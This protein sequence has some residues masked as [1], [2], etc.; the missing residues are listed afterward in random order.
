ML[1]AL[2]RKLVDRYSRANAIK[3]RR[4]ARPRLELLE[5][6]L[7]PGSADPANVTA[8][9]DAT[10]HSL[11][12]S[13]QEAIGSKDTPVYGAAFLDPVTPSANGGLTLSA[14]TSNGSNVLNFPSGTTTLG[15]LAGQTV[16]GS[17]IQS[18]TTI[19]SVDSSTQVTLSTPA[20]ATSLATG[21]SLTF[22]MILTGTLT[23]G[24]S[25]VTGLSST[26]GLFVGQSLL[27]TGIPIPQ[28][29]SNPTQGT[30]EIT[31]R[32]ASIGADGHSL[33]LT[34]NATANGAQSLTFITG[35]ALDGS[36]MQFMSGIIDN[37]TVFTQTYTYS[38]TYQNPFL[39]TTPP[40]VCMTLYHNTGVASGFH[41]VVGDGPGLNT[42]NSLNNNNNSGN[43]QVYSGLIDYS[44]SG[45]A[46]AG[47]STPTAA[48]NGTL[49]N[50]STTVTGLS[51][52]NGMYV[53]EYV[54][55][56]G[57][58]AGAQIASIVNAS[59]ITLTTA[60]T[61]TGGKSLTFDTVTVLGYRIINGALDLNHD[62]AISS[63]DTTSTLAGHPQF[64]GFNVIGG[65]VDLNGNGKI[66]SNDTGDSGIAAICATPTIINARSTATLSGY[67]TDAG[68]GGGIS[69]VTI[70]LTQ[71]DINGNVLAT[72][73]TTTDGGGYY[74]FGSLPAGTYSITEDTT[75]LPPG[76]NALNSFPGTDNGTM[77]GTSLS[78]SSI[79][80]ITLNS[81]DVGTN[82]N[83]TAGPV[84]V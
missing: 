67:V 9:Y 38:S 26:A 54:T 36:G 64:A 12:V 5:A 76:Y 17:G 62:G 77:D 24:S 51:S 80:S 71:Y 83:F 61:V 58:H 13:F 72:F 68:T 79:S 59:T 43:Y 8:I 2:M 18:G 31:T 46:D 47:D 63:A 32:I 78:A 82:F 19:A 34:A 21:T 1:S 53:G 29:P 4:R 41:S 56:S 81:G 39:L 66:D 22:T 10:A 55:G 70:T 16:T 65:K 57:L 69:G 14:V 40:D 28:L 6:R 73:T 27:G 74:S 25:V 49:T 7:N 45:K 20:T 75:T 48:M 52:T 44:L 50:G 33:T 15:L 3:P 42:D 30:P 37:T 84:G 60:A 11:S 35:L 23:S